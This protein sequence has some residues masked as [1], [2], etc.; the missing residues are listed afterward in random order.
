[1]TSGGALTTSAQHA[2]SQDIPSAR[3]LTPQ[4]PLQHL[5]WGVLRTGLGSACRAQIAC[6]V[7]CLG[8][9]LAAQ[10]TGQFV[11]SLLPASSAVN[12]LLLGCVCL[13]P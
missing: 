12:Y 10:C 4:A 1:M 6:R 13:K 5:L 7:L 9:L 2:H 3:F 8:E 11:I